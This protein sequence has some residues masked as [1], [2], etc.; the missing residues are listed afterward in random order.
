MLYLRIALYIACISYALGFF[1]YFNKFISKE[2][3]VYTLFANAL[4]FVSFAALAYTSYK[5][6]REQDEKK[7]KSAE[8]NFTSKPVN[9][10]YAILGAY[11]MLGLLLPFDIKFN[12]YYIFGLLGYTLLAFQLI[13]GMYML[14]I[15]YII[16]IFR[17]FYFNK[18][19]D[20]ETIFILMNKIGL[21]IYFGTYT[22][23]KIK[24]YVTPL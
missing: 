3:T 18:T 10:V 17:T 22:I 9:Y 8:Y 7:V 16:S 12:H 2:N 23:I 20:R 19:F 24:N 14:V 15:F 1:I 4:L 13:Y 6:A 11:F 5:H 21:L